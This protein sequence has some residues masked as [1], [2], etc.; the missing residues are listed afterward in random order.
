MIKILNNIS[1]Q[2]LVFL[3]IGLGSYFTIRSRFV[4]FRYF[5]HMFGVL[6]DAFR[7]NKQHITS[8]QALMISIA[9]RVGSGNIAGGLERN[10]AYFEGSRVEVAESVTPELKLLCFDP[11]TSGGLLLAV[12]PDAVDT[13]FERFEANKIPAW[14][15]GVVTDGAGVRIL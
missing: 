8:F 12:A 1:G 11:Q 6:R 10:L 15:I 9:G 7:P 5:S 13:L 2:I 14:I 4:Q 3:L